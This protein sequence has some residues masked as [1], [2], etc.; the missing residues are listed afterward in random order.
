MNGTVHVFDFVDSRSTV[1]PPPVCPFFG[2]ERFLQQLAVAAAKRRWAG[3]DA[4]FS[5][6]SFDGDSC[7]WV[8]V[9]DAWSS[10]SLF[11]RNQQQ[12][13]IL[14]PADGFVRN[15]RQQLETLVEAG[16]H[17]G[18]LI[19]LVDSWAANTRLYQRI[20]KTGLQVQCDAPQT[21]RGKG[22]QRD[23]T[24]IAKWLIQR[25]RDQYEFVLTQP[26]AMVL[27]ELTQ[28]CFGRMDQELAK[29]SL[30]AMDQTELS[31]AQIRQIVGGWPAQTMW[32]AIEAALDGRAGQA[33][34]L[35]GQLVHA[36]EHPLAMF[37]Q[38]SWSLRRYADVG[39]RVMRDFRQRKR[40]NLPHTL[41]AAGF[42]NWGNEI[43]TAE[44]HLKQLGQKRVALLLD[45]LVKT[46]QA[47]KSTHSREDRG[48]LI[49]ELLVTR[50]A[51]ELSPTRKQ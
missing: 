44:R 8:D 29:I 2:G 9:H 21:T 14:D 47:L 1:S 36:G 22:K 23:D 26:A 28:C 49:L 41:A 31:P 32:T 51:E 12:L 40:I 35:L 42:R 3:D 13:V 48:R 11:S 39:S 45:Q 7:H 27:M 17:G 15:H 38:I 6:Q 5:V 34:D 4:E 18:T 16:N 46:D 25:A 10:R 37:G 33:L 50:L 30:Y 24:R 43:N 20:D 19:L